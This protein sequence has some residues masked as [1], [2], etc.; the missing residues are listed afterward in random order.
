MSDTHEEETEELEMDLLDIANEILDDHAI[1][2]EE[3]DRMRDCVLEDGAIDQEEAEMLFAINDAIAEGVSC[4]EYEDFFVEMITAFLLADELSDGVLDDTEWDWLRAMVGEDGDLD[5]LEVKLLANIA[6]ES[7]SV[8]KGF[9]DFA[10]QF[11]EVEYEDADTS[12]ATFLA[13]YM[14]GVM[15]GKVRKDENQY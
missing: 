7:T 14:Q 9:F 13:N 4:P 8:P 3:V 5:E 6:K 11:E 10:K 1:D 12:R 2:P 15:K